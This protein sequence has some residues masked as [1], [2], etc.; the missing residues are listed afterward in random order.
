M[1]EEQRLAIPHTV[2]AALASVAMACGLIG[3]KTYAAWTTGSVA[4]L[5]SL[6][7]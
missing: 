3:L 5:G 6:A 1:T 7:D 4:M 2:R